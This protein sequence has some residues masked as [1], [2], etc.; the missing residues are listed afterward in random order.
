MEYENNPCVRVHKPKRSLCFFCCFRHRHHLYVQH[1]SPPPPPQ[2]SFNEENPVVIWDKTKGPRDNS[3][4]DIREKCRSMLGL[5]GSRKKRHSSADFRYDPLSYSLNFE[6]GFRCDEEAPF[7]N[8]SARLP[9]SPPLING[10]E[11]V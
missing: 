4:S 11:R 1:P 2:P 7:R 10:F 5:P 9:P 6:D 3:L 8:F